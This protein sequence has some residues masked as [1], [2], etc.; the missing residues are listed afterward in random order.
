MVP[1]LLCLRLFDRSFLSCT[2]SLPSSERHPVDVMMRP[3]LRPDEN[4]TV[5]SFEDPR[6]TV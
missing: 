2:P 3:S 4:T 5:G 1:G 6:Q